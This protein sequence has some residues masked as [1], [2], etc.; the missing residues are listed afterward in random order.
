MQKIVLIVFAILFSIPTFAQRERSLLKIRDQ[1]GRMITAEINGRRYNKVG[2]MLTF[3]DLPTRN[4]DVKVY[5]VNRTRNG[6]KAR[7]IYEGRL[8]TK[9]GKIYYVT[10]DDYEGLD[11]ITDC[12]L[13][14][15]GPWNEPNTW[16]RSRYY[17]QQNW[18]EKI[19]FD[20]QEDTYYNYEKGDRNANNRRRGNTRR[21]R[22]NRG[23][24]SQGRGN[25][26]DWDHYQNSMS[27]ARF[28]G[29]MQQVNDAG[30]E[31]SRMT[32]IEQAIAKNHL[33]TD[34]LVKIMQ[35]LSFESSRLTIAKMAYPKLVD[36]EN[37]YKVNQGFSFSSSKD[38]YNRFVRAQGQ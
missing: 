35:A 38:E 15:N 27:N 21:G 29:M 5:V 32:I 7:L 6:R 16:Y 3:K 23:D 18:E 11:I 12:C 8:R 9:P 28:N 33:N 17:D 30:F 1:E 25:R 2:K 37:I 31:S 10:V 20:P 13:G 36:Q 14:D 19:Q 34:Q 26:D 4:H 22:N 24:N